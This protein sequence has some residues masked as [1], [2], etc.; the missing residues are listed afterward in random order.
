M[1]N[2]LVSIIIPTRNRTAYLKNSL[3]SVLDQTYRKLEVIVIDDASTD[4]TLNFLKTIKDKRLKVILLKKQSGAQVARNRGIKMSKAEFIAFNDDDDIWQ[5]DKLEKQMAIFEKD[6]EVG[7]VYCRIKRID[8]KESFFMPKE[9]LSGQENVREALFLENNGIGLPSAIVKRECFKKAGFFDEKLPRYQDWELW[10]RISKFYK[11]KFLPE[12]LVVSYL[13]PDGITKDKRVLLKATNIIFKK[14]KKEILKKPKRAASWFFRLGDLYYHERNLKKA[15]NY[16]KKACEKNSCFKYKRAIV[17]TYLGKNMSEF[18]IKLKTKFLENKII[19][20]ILGIAFGLRVIDINQSFWLDESVQAMTSAGS[21]KN[22]FLELQGDF[23][24]PFYHVFMWVWARIFDNREIA[25]RLPSLVLG[26][27]T[28][29]VVYKIACFIKETSKIKSL[30]YFP[31]IASLFMATAPFHIYYSQEAR[32]YSMTCFLASLSILFFLPVFMSIEKPSKKDLTKYILA[33]I[34][35]LYTNYFAV[36]VVLAQNLAMLL[37]YKSL[38]KLKSWIFI[39]LFLVFLFSPIFLLLAKQ[40]ALG[41]GATAAL[42]EWRR[43]VNAGFLKALPLTFAKFSIGKITIFDKRLYG[44]LIIMLFVVHAV[45]FVKGFLKEKK[46]LFQRPITVIFIWLFIPVGLAFLT[47]FFIPNFQPFRLLLV[48]PAFYLILSFG[49][50]FFKEKIKII[51]AGLI[52][53]VNLASAFAYFTNPYFKR[54]DWR[55]LTNYIEQRQENLVVVFPSNTSDWAFRYYSS[56]EEKPLSASQGFSQVTDKS[57]E[58]LILKIEEE[59]IYYIRYLIP[60]FDPQ[61]IFVKTLEKEGF[62]KTEEISFNQLL[63]WKFSRE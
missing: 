27:L 8:E 36:F 21:F 22:L 54:E 42:P 37:K 25:M 39:Q 23:H 55:G 18:L 32:N 14:Y 9:G 51:L 49:L 38:K 12:T 41:K 59:E 17:K 50:C 7:V 48:L 56:V 19:F 10:L 33:T 58:E 46:A 13:L 29:A 16:F 62:E 57:A 11:F 4:K 43:L 60:M 28:I 35:F 61:G 31:L 1:F 30:K 34:F 20:L 15:R 44:A 5:K 45:I 40:L 3:K 63:I 26:S 2:P 52:L 53:V 47:S 24:P 6:K